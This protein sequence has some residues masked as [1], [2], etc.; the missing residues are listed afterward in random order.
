[1]NEE[2]K[3]SHHSGAP[4]SADVTEMLLKIQQHLSYLEKKIDTLIAQSAPGASQP[5]RG[6]FPQRHRPFV[7]GGGHSSHGA[8]GKRRHEGPR[9]DF[10]PRSQSG[11]DRRGDA[12]PRREGGREFFQKKKRFPR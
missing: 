4:K 10:H 3:Q 9:R 1:M 8:P 5:T 6:H 7:Q 12:P 11:D 2:N